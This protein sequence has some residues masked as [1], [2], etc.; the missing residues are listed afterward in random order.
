MGE[1]SDNQRRG[2]YAGHCEAGQDTKSP[3]GRSVVIYANLPVVT[4][5]VAV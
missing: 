3:L 4:N 2:D 5:G 1:T